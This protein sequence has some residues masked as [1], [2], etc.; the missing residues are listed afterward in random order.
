MRI[1]DVVVPY[2]LPDAG[3]HSFF[4][5]DQSVRPCDEAKFHSHDAW[6]ILVV[7]A[8]SGSFIAGDVELQFTPGT[9]ALVAPGL[10][11]RWVYDETTAPAD[12]FVHYRM[13]AFSQRF[14][15]RL[16]ETF[17]EMAMRL[18]GVVFPKGAVLFGDRAADHID[19]AFERMTILDEIGRLA[20][21]LRLRGFVFL[22]NDR[23]TAGR[24]EALQAD[25]RRLEA[26]EAIIMRD[27]A[28]AMRLEAIAR[29]LGMTATAFSTFFHRS[30]GVTFQSF[31][32]DYRLR[33]AAELLR[34][35]AKPVAETARLAGFRDCA[36]FSRMFRR[37][38]GMSPRTF[39]KKY[40]VAD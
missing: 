14:V 24:T 31:L 25:R 19:R 7:K 39:R 3:N 35:T 28:K 29:E 9:A 26:A 21:M 33:V 27:Y 17:P 32:L 8:G 1:S 23:Q 18:K 4:F 6:E 12:G 15:D 36:H 13:C 2:S 30:K 38:L 20:E 11:H 16:I 22:T 34:T 5:I 40:R 37:Q 10:P